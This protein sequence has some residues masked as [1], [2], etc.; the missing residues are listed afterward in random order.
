MKL[1]RFLA[2]ARPALS[3]LEREVA[4]TRA[5]LNARGLG[6]DAEAAALARLEVLATAH[7]A[8]ASALRALAF[9][10]ATR[11]GDFAG[12]AE[13]F[14]RAFER[15]SEASDAFDAARAWDQVDEVR[16]YEWLQRIPEAERSAFPRVA[17]YQAKAAL[18]RGERGSALEPLLASLSR[19][20]ATV[21]GRQLPGVAAVLAEL[22]QAAGR[23]RLAAI[24]AEADRAERHRRAAPLLDHARAGLAEGHF[25]AATQAL[26]QA[27]S[28]VPGSPELLELQARVAAARGDAKGAERALGVLRSQA[29]S[30]PQ[31]IAHENSLR[32]DL[33]LPLLPLLDADEILA[34]AP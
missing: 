8:D 21:E 33:G 12:A 26:S 28:L 25:D 24:H 20:R 11:R 22:A 6:P 31:A 18:R 27:T 14:G 4:E 9:H 13:A 29:S 15:R 23:P 10:L 30:A 34:A 7:P 19:F 16:A 32:R 5:S 17:L 1:Q 2:D 3:M